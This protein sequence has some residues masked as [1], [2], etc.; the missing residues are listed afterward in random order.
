MPALTRNYGYT[1]LSAIS[2]NRLWIFSTGLLQSMQTDWKTFSERYCRTQQQTQNG[3]AEVLRKQIE[4]FA[5]VGF[6]IAEAQ[7]FGSSWF[8][9]VVILPYGPNNTF[10]EIP[11]KPFTPRGLASDTSV[12]IM[13]ILAGE[14]PEA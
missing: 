10:K 1:S 11:T 4:R 9:T 13:S 6:F 2:R 14:V 8:G 12:A 3:L 7:D 5:P